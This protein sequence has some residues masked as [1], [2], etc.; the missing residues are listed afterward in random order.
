MVANA[1]IMHGGINNRVDKAKIKIFQ[2]FHYFAYINTLNLSKEC[3]AISYSNSVENLTFIAKCGAGNQW[4]VYHCAQLYL[5]RG[6][7]FGNVRLVAA[8]NR[9][10]KESKSGVTM[11]ADNN[12]L[13][14]IFSFVCLIPAMLMTKQNGC[15]RV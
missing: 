5:N 12:P 2:L 1:E 7:F 4:C 10:T 8:L 15:P 14:L 9:S 13:R 6:T 11:V 3:V